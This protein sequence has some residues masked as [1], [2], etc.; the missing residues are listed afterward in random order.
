MSWISDWMFSILFTLNNP[1]V[2]GVLAFL[3]AVAALMGLAAS[4]HSAQNKTSDS[5]ESE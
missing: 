1:A 2:W 3:V 5:G 4:I